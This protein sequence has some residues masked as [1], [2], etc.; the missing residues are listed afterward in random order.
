MKSIV[1]V[2]DVTYELPDGRIL[3]SNLNFSLDPK[4]SALVG[5]NGVGKTCL[6]KLISGELEPTEGVIRRQAPI[7]FFPQRETAPEMTVDEFLAL[8][9]SWSPLGEK[10]LGDINRQTLCTHLSG[11]QWMRVRLA[12]NIGEQFLILDEPTNDLDRE[13]RN[14]IFEFLK[15]APSGVLLISHDREALSLCKDILELS[16]KGLSKYGDGWDAYE[17]AKEQERG[18]L[19]SALSFAKK[20]RDAAITQR[21]EQKTKQ[22]K[23]NR[24]G[25]KETARGGMPRIIIGM[26]KRKAQSTTGKIDASTL[27]KANEAVRN[28]F[29]AFT[30]LKIDPVMYA[31]VLGKELPTQKLIAEAKDFN[32]KFQNWIYKKDLNFSWRGNIRLALKGTNGSGKSTLL[33]AILGQEFESR[34]ELRRGNLITLY[35]DQQ[36]AI[37]DESKS[38]FENIRDV[39]TADESEIRNGLAKFLFTKDKVFQKVNSLSG[40]ERLRAALAKGLLS[41]I[42]PELLILDEPTNNLDLTNIKFLEDLAREFKGALLVISH[43]E[44]FLQN[45]GIS[46]EFFL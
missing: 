12:K 20:D 14:A 11:G 32:I 40:G 43:D 27:E 18:H 22:E 1:I 16:N 4:V 31:E 33:K 6:A 36:C 7:T 44:V 8:D 25:A 13:G 34:G 15:E 38:I 21:H 39:S 45:C 2:S 17:E 23:R 9:Y 28:A 46:D 5:A 37:L 42:K 41:T 29:E 10:L 30:D 3:F 24:Q 19:E 26:R 35:I